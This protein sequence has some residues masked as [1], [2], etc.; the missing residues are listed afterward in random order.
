MKIL[1]FIIGKANPNRPNGVNYV[2]HGHCKY[3]ASHGHQVTVIGLSKNTR[4]HEIVDR[5][6][7]KVSVFRNFFRG[8]LPE[9]I[10]SLDNV[11]I[12]HLH[13]V[14]K[15]YNS[16]VAFFCKKFNKPYV[17]TTHSGLAEDRIKQSKYYLKK[18]YHFLFQKK[19]FD[20]S[21]GVHSITKE[22]IFDNSKMTKNDNIFFVPNGI[23]LT[24][25][26]NDD[27]GRSIENPDKIKFGYLGRFAI[28]KNVKSLIL[29]IS[30]LPSNIIE[31]VECQLIGP[32][33]NDA[34]KLDILIKKLDLQEQIIFTGPLYG[35]EKYNALRNLDFYV[36]PAFSDVVSIAVMEAMACGLPL[37]ITRT[38]QVAYYYD[39]NSFIMVEPTI[40][41]INKGIAK[42]IELQH[43]WQEMSNNAINLVNNRLSWEIVSREMVQEYKKILSDHR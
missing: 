39:S 8:C 3:A 25:I 6:G 11:D 12:V 30:K 42:M 2:I 9:I 5:E 33:D 24:K 20:D 10:K 40:N 35:S 27:L 18:L 15:P 36:H 37:V 41:E 14:W 13:S 1:H 22:E 38:S 17:V 16:I 4:K 19:L 32:I 26:K 34:K 43:T 28:E 23:D 7:F 29:A 21:S 31:K